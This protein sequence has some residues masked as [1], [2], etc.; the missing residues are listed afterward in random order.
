MPLDPHTASRRE[1]TKPV[2]SW[3]R[4][5]NR[6]VRKVTRAMGPLPSHPGKIGALTWA[7]SLKDWAGPFRYREPIVTEYDYIRY[8][9]LSQL[10]N[11]RP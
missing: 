10:R 7:T 2:T 9:P 6:S 3:D 4:W 1:G 5:Y 8:T 11:P